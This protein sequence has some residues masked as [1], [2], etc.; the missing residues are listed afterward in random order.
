MSDPMGRVPLMPMLALALSRRLWI[1]WR[2]PWGGPLVIQGRS[3]LWRGRIAVGAVGGEVLLQMGWTWG[4]RSLIGGFSH[5]L[6]LAE[7]VSVCAWWQRRAPGIP[8]QIHSPQGSLQIGLSDPAQTGWLW[9]LVWC[10]P[11]GPL[12][13]Q[14]RFDQ[15]G[16]RSRGQMQLQ[17]RGYGWPLGLSWRIK[18]IHRR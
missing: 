6:S 3:L 10:L 8:F 2:K 1:R 12:Q 5:S 14:L 18:G 17:W 11:Q 13:I 4:R 7:V 9:G 15:I 16:W